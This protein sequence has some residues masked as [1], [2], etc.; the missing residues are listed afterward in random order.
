[1]NVGTV[2]DLPDAAAWS[3]LEQRFFEAAPPDVPEPPAP[4]MRFDDLAAAQPERVNAATLRRVRT[5]AS[6]VRTSVSRLAAAARRRSR[7]A[8]ARARAQMVNA[9]ATTGR[10]AAAVWRCSSAALAAA[11][12]AAW[13][14]VRAAGGR[15]AATLVLE[16]AARENVGI[17]VASLILLFGL[18]AGVA[19][20]RGAARSMLPGTAFVASVRGS[21]DPIS[22]APTVETGEPAIADEGLLPSPPAE[23]IA[24]DSPPRAH[25]ATKA[26]RRHHR[27]VA[28]RSP[29]SVPAKPTPRP[30]AG[31][32]GSRLDR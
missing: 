1:M 28:L 29:R 2:L 13:R 8:V 17:A 10:A 6:T 4:A 15:L 20:S 25:T 14:T 11:G 7:P 3:E 18:S 19:A 31:K 24:P 27:L 32:P 9:A 12:G 21:A 26:A 22:S 16:R 30:A 23:L 5:A